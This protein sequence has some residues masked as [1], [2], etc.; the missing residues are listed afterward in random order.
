S[1][2]A[3]ME[4]VPGKD[5]ILLP[6]L[7][8]DP[9]FSSSFKNSPDA[10]FKPSGEEEKKNTE[11]DAGKKVT[12]I[13]K[14]ESR[15]SNK[16]DNQDLRD[17]FKSLIQHE[18]NGENDVSST[19]KINTVSSTINAAGIEDNVADEYIVYGCADDPNMPNLE[20]IV[21]SDDD[22]GVGV[23]ADMTNAVF[24][25]SVLFAICWD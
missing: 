2:K 15:I 16:E 5:F 18:K 10:G 13:P 17:E 21:Y 19:N 6:F 3:K 23:E 4:T 1:R 14:K 12:E 9:P 11:D 7:T 20:E 24:M 22:E 25:Y 8:Q